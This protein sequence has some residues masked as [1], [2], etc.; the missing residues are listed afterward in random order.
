MKGIIFN[1]LE[2]A[3]VR[4]FGHDTWDDV[5]DDADV[6]GAYTS[7]GNYDDSELA[8]LIN[9]LPAATGADLADRLRWVGVNAVPFLGKAFPQSFDNID[10]RRFLPTLNHIIHPEVRK[11]YPGATPPDFEIDERTDGTISLRYESQRQ[12]CWLAEGFVLGVAN[13]LGEKVTLSQPVCMYT[14]AHYCDIQ[15]AFHE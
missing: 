13:R 9:A 14:G 6:T 8:S 11:L 15:I 10:L 1:A 12:L 3:V 5:L 7:P 4:N 2:D